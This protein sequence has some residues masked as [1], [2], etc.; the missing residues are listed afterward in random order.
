MLP[1]SG[2]GRG[3]TPTLLGLLERA[4]LNH[5]T[6]DCFRPHLSTET[7]PVSETLSSLVSRIPDDR[8]S[9][10]TQRF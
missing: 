8:Q 10:K 7:D 3:K 1:S 4:N 9:P 2:E 5:W 6:S